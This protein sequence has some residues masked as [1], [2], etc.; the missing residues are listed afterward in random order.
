MDARAPLASS[1][2]SSLRAVVTLLTPHF[3][4]IKNRWS[5]RHGV[6]R[7]ELVSCLLVVLM[8]IGLYCCCV[9][10]LRE[11]A[12]ATPDYHLAYTPIMSALALAM[13]I[14][15]FL[16]SSISALSAL[17]VSK[18]MDFLLSAPVSKPTLL[19]AKMCE[20]AFSICWMLVVFGI[21]LYISF[22]EALSAGVLYYTGAPIVIV[23]LLSPAVLLGTATAVI[24]SSLLPARGGRHAFALLFAVS[25]GLFFAILNNGAKM[26]LPS[27]GS[28]SSLLSVLKNSPPW[29][30]L[31]TTQI[32]R[33]IEGLARGEL[34]SAALAITTY[35]A[36][37]GVSW[38]ISLALFQRLFLRTHTKLQVSNSP[39]QLDSRF[40]R[41]VARVLFAMTRRGTRALVTKEVYAFSRELTQTL[42]LTMLLT[43]CALYSYNFSQINP[44]TKVGVEILQ[45]WDVFMTALNVLLGLMVILSISSRF[46]FP[47]VSLEGGSLWI[48]QSAPVSTRDIL[49]A[50]YTSWFSLIVLV[51]LSVFSAGG[52][53]IG[54]EPRVIAASAISGIIISHGLVTLGLGFGARF[55]R[56]DWEHQGQIATNTGNFVYMVTGIL[57]LGI[58]MI[59]V[60]IMFGAYY[61]LPMVFRDDV[62]ALMLLASGV[63]V[64]SVINITVGRVAISIGARA[65]QRC[66]T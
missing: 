54:V 11:L 63:T 58:N 5:S 31:P 52:F 42:Q 13:F 57:L 27:G 14:M 29:Y 44:P 7:K 61:L 46:V 21:P 33:A 4:S 18:D 20:T 35:A 65:L 53:A 10:M 6:P 45:L 51:A 36:V 32:S 55:A 43:I 15:V 34:S 47:S 40:G 2:S 30:L 25:I 26:V 48:L 60:T 19:I 22:G 37:T 24:F 41:S 66:L 16:S 9:S 56:F 38:L 8:M 12:Q 62:A 64:L 23:A 50:K 17:Y 49:R 1:D 39:L 28:T 3:L 59:P